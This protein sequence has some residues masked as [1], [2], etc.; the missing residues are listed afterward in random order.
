MS[1]LQNHFIKKKRLRDKSLKYSENYTKKEFIIIKSNK[2]YFFNLD[3]DEEKKKI[4]ITCLSSS[5]IYFEI[6]LDLEQLKKKCRIFNAC[7]TLEDA[8]KIIFNLF[9]N[10]KVKIREEKTDSILIVLHLLN[11]IIDKEEEVILNLE[12]NKKNITLNDNLNE[13]NKKKGRKNIII[14]KKENNDKKIELDF[15]Q[16]ILTLCKKDQIKNNQIERLEKNLKELLKAHYSIKKDIISL[17]RC[18]G[19]NKSIISE[20]NIENEEQ[21]NDEENEYNN[22]YI[23]DKND[24]KNEENEYN[25]EEN[26]YIQKGKR[27]GKYTEKISK[28]KIIKI[29]EIKNRT[30]NK[31]KSIPKMVFTKNLTKKAICRYLGDNN[32]AVFKT[33]N[34]EI[35]LAYGTQYYSIHFYNIDNERITKRITNAHDSEITNFR[36]TYD[37]NYNR[38]LLLSVSN[39]IKN[40]KVWDVQNLNCM[41]S[42]N[43]A[44]KGGNLF[45]SCFL[46]DENYKK[47]YIISIN[48]D[49]ENLK[50]FDFE[51]KKIKEI[52]NSEDK[53][54][55]VDTYYNTKTKKY[56]I[57]VGNEKYIV[58]Y[59]FGDGS[60]FHKYWDNNSNSWH[61][62]FV[63]SSKDKEVNLIES[64]TIGYVRIWDFNKGILLKKLLIEKKVRLRGICMW[65]YKYFFVGAEDKKLKL[66]DLENNI[67]VDNLKCNDCVC[68]I[69]KI[70]SSKF[71]ECLILQGKI[72]NYQIKLWRNENSK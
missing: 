69:K 3:I 27:K 26:E 66:I 22:E 13:L 58:S 18:V 67:E 7:F 63:L 45:S 21:Y 57:V 31:S 6:N 42:I 19:Y 59:N 15:E 20:E 61:M 47:N 8:Y 56:Y 52:D 2:K 70:N 41:I 14:K 38:D 72:D 9:K 64:D 23:D 68:T 43:N 17:G 39:Q 16:K 24:G 11:Y 54:F 10:K 49:K 48:Y 65:N 36:Y 5:E 60:I 25:Y 50:I 53:C 55:L 30:E 29:K 44:Y 28:L 40:I 62:N 34:K 1:Q 46:I 12:K 32:F 71:G 35:I 4:Q 33:I 37:K 51:G